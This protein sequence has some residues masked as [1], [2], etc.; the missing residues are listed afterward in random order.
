MPAAA[1]R[2]AGPEMY[3]QIR[4]EDVDAA[5]RILAKDFVRTTALDSDDLCHAHAVFDPLAAETVC[6]ACGCTF[7][8]SIGACPECGLSFE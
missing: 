5:W 3:L 7:S 8:P 6:P 2:D 4:K 1:A